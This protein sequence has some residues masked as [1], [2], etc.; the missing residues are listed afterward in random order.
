MR[1]RAGNDEAVCKPG[2]LIYRVDADVDTGH[3]PVTVSDSRRDSGGCTRS[4]ERPRGTLRR[5]V[6]ARGG[7]SGTDGGGARS[8]WR[9]REVS[10]DS[11]LRVA[12][13]GGGEARV[14]V[15]VGVGGDG[16][17]QVSRN[18]ALGKPQADGSGL[19]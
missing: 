9:G 17:T 19:P 5:A 18:A 10:G 3:G 14:R 15:D 2:V 13:S 4:P 7:R 11:G 12:G 6:H 16:R 8:R 1:T